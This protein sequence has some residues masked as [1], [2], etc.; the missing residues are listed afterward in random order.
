MAGPLLPYTEETAKQKV[1]RAQDLWNSQ[2]PDEIAKAYT[3]TC[4]WRN[5]DQFF[6]GTEAI[7]AFL[8]NKFAKEINYKLRKELFAFTDNKIAVQFWYEYQDP[9]DGMKWKRCYGIEHWTFETEGEHAG[10]MRQRMM[11]GN[12]VL[13]GEGGN[14]EGRWYE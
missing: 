6:S 1:Q 9:N 11:S 12:D 3:P 5:R 4:T 2:N 14:G 13:I 7:K 8:T 10:K